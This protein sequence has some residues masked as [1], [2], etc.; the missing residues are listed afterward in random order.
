MPGGQSVQIVL[1]IVLGTG[2]GLL[3]CLVVDRLLKGYGDRGPFAVATG[4]AAR[5]AYVAAAVA[6]AAMAM[7]GAVVGSTRGDWATTLLTSLVTGICWTVSVIDLRVRR[8]PN[9]L[10]IA[11]ALVALAQVLLL[12]QPAPGRALLGGLVGTAV[13]GVLFAL[14]RGAMGLGD[15]KFVAA[16]GLLLGY[17]GILVG[18]L[19][20]IFVGGLAALLLLISRKAGRKDPMAYGPYLA[21]GIWAFWAVQH[22][23]A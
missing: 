8:I 14:G 17:P 12:G 15:V 22:V 5:A 16:S 10:V 11:L 21:L 7:L 2:A 23:L 6:V 20:G 3:A 19:W 13:F 18:M 9:V 1:G 4:S